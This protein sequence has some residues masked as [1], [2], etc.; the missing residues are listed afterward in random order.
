ME[1]EDYPAMEKDDVIRRIEESRRFVLR[2]TER[3]KNEKC[4]GFYTQWMQESHYQ[5]KCTN[6][7]HD[8]LHRQRMLALYLLRFDLVCLK[9]YD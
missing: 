9:T 8:K 6:D 2:V 7:D 4:C 3:L 5:V 1:A